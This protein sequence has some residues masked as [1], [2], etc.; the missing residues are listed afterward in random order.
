MLSY[1]FTGLHGYVLIFILMVLEG[2]SL[3]IPS[4]V[5][6]PLVGYYASLGLIDPVLGVLAGTLGSLV[7]SLIDYYMAYY[8]GLPFLIKYGRLFGIDKN[9]LNAL[10]RWFSRYGVFAVFGFRFLPGFRALISFPAGLA[11]MR[12]VSFIVVT[13]LGHLV[14]DSILAYIGFSFA[15]EWSLIIGLIDRYLYVITGI[16]VVIIL[17]YIVL[18][19]YVKPRCGDSIK[20]CD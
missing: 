13:F 7:G 20:L 9:R 16:A 4:E 19:L 14:W 5:V 18:R 17:V 8:L 10:N 3:P 2:M 1:V 15:A 12:I 11:D 6:M